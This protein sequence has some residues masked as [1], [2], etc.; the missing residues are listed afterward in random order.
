MIFFDET[1]ASCEAGLEQ[2]A[3]RNLQTRILEC[4]LPV[5]VKLSTL[6]TQDRIERIFNMLCIVYREYPLKL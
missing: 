1:I 2:Y 4:L 6:L 5:L 3:G